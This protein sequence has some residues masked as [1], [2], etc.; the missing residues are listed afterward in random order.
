MFLQGKTS[1]SSTSSS[2]N[3]NDYDNNNSSSSK[4]T[5]RILS[6]PGPFLTPSPSPSISASPRLQPS[7]SLSPFPQDVLLV[8]G[9]PLTNANA[10]EQERKAV[11]PGRRQSIHQFTN[12][13]PNAGTVVFQPS[14]SQ[15]PA[16][17]TS[18]IGITANAAGGLNLVGNFQNV[19]TTTATTTGNDLNATLVGS[20]NIQLNKKG[21]K[22]QQQQHQQ[23]QQQQHHQIFSSSNSHY[24]NSNATTTTNPHPPHPSSSSIAAAASSVTS[25]SSTTATIAGGYG[26]SHA[27]TINN[28]PNT[29]AP[30]NVACTPK[31]Q[32]KK[33]VNA[34]NQQSNNTTASSSSA[35]LPISQQQHQQ[36]QQYHSG[37]P[38]IADSPSPSPSG[39]TITAAS[40]KPPTPQP[41]QPPTMQM[42]QQQFT[43]ASNGNGGTGPQQTFQLIQGPQG[44]IIA[45]ATSAPQHQQQARFTTTPTGNLTTTTTGG[46]TSATM[47]GNA[48]GNKLPQQIL[49]KPQQ[50]QQQQ[51]QILID[52]QKHKQGNSAGPNPTPPPSHQTVT[53]NATSSSNLSQQHQQQQ[54]ASLT[55]ISQSA[56]PG[57]QQ[58]I[59]PSGA[60]ASLT[61]TAGQQP[62]LLL[63]QV[64]M[65]VQQ[66]AP[67]G[68]QLILRPPTP[69][70]TATPS[71]VIQ[72]ARPQPQLQQQQP[73]QVLRILGHNG[74]TMQLA[75][76]TPTFIVS[77]QANLIQQANHLQAIKTQPQ[78]S[79]ITQLSGL[80]AALSAAA[81]ANQQPRSQQFTTTAATINGHLLGPSMAAQLQNLQLAAAAAANGNS[82]TAQIQMPNGLSASGAPT[83][84]SQ[85]PA[86]TG[87]TQFQQNS[88][89]GLINLNQLSNANIQ[90][91]AAAAAAAA[92][93]GATTFQA[94]G[95]PPSNNTGGQQGTQNVTGNTNANQTTTNDLYTTSLTQS[96]PA[97]VPVS[98]TPEPLSRQP[99]PVLQ[100]M[101]P[102]PS[103]QQHQHQQQHQQTVGGNG[104]I[105]LQFN[106]AATIQMQQ[107]QQ[108]QQQ[109]Q[110]QQL[111]QQIQQTQNQVQQAQQQAQALQ[112]Q[113]QQMQ[114]QQQQPPPPETKKKAKPRRRKPPATSAAANANT[115]GAASSTASPA[116]VKPLTT[117]AN[118]TLNTATSTTSVL[119]PAI[120]TSNT[121]TKIVPMLSQQNSGNL[122]TVQTTATVQQQQIQQNVVDNQ[123][124]QHQQQ[125][126]TK[127]PSPPPQITRAS[128]G[129]LD[130]GNVMKLCGI[131]EDDDEDFMDTT[132]IEETNPSSS[133]QMSNPSTDYTISIPQANV[134]GGD[135]PPPSYTLSIPGV[136]NDQMD[137]SG[138]ETAAANIVIKI[139]PSTE[140]LGSASG[141]TSGPPGHHPPY[142]I[143]IPRLPSQEE[144]QKQ[145]QQHLQ[146]AQNEAQQIKTSMSGGP[147]A[148][149]TFTLPL[150]TAGPTSIALGSS[151]ASSSTVTTSATSTTN[152]TTTTATVK[153][154]RKPAAKRNTKKTD[155]TASTATTVP[156]NNSTVTVSSSTTT[157]SFG[158]TLPTSSA[159]IVTLPSSQNSVQPNINITT[160]SISTPLPTP[161][162]VPSQIGNIQ[163]SQIDNRLAGQ[164]G[165]TTMVSTTPMGSLVENKIQ[166]M[167]ILDKSAATSHQP[168]QTQI[169]FQPPSLVQNHQ[170]IG[171]ANISAPLTT[172]L[173]E[174]NQQPR[175]MHL[176]SLPQLSNSSVAS[177]SSSPPVQQQQQQPQTQTAPP[178]NSVL[179]GLTGNVSISVGT[180]NTITSLIPQLTGSLTLAVS[181]QCERL[182][183]RH[184]PNKPQDQQSQLILQAL[185]KGALPN[186]TIINEPLKPVEPQQQ[187]QQQQQHSQVVTNVIQQQQ[188]QQQQQSATPTTVSTGPPSGNAKGSKKKQQQQQQQHVAP[189]ASKTT[190]SGGGVTK[191][192]EPTTNTTTAVQPQSNM[193]V[194]T[195]INNNPAPVPQQDTISQ[196]RYLSLPKID[197]TTQQLFCLNSLNNQIT[198]IGANQTTTSIGPTERILI[199]P[200]G[201]NAQQLAQCLQLGQIHFNDANPLP[202]SSQI[203]QNNPPPSLTNTSTTLPVHP[204]N[205]AGSI[206]NNSNTM[207]GPQQPP[208]QQIVYPMTSGSSTC[209]TVQSSS[210]TITT[211]TITTTTTTTKQVA[212][213]APIIDQSKAAKQ[214]N[215]LN[216]STTTTTTTTS[217]TGAVPKK[218]PVRKPKA[219]TTTAADVALMKN[220]SVVKPLPKLDPLS[221]KPH[222]NPVQI[223]QPNT[224]S[225]KPVVSTSTTST[226]T[227]TSNVVSIQPF[228]TQTSTGTKLVGITA[229]MQQQPQL[230]QQQ[231]QQQLQQNRTL[232]SGVVPTLPQPSIANNTTSSTGL[233]MSLPTIQPIVSTG[234]NLQ[235]QQPQHTVS[236]VQTIQLTQQQEQMLR[237]VQM[238]IQY[239]TVKMQHKNLISSMPLPADLD[240]SVVAAFN[241]PMSDI[242][243]N[244]SL[245]RLFMEQH[246]I[247]SS[248]KEISTSDQFITNSIPPNSSYNLGTFNLMSNTNQSQSASNDNKGLS[249]GGGIPANVVQPN[250][251]SANTSGVGGSTTTT[252]ALMSPAGNMQ[253]QQQQSTQKIHIYPIQHQ[254]HTTVTSTTTTSVAGTVLTSGNNKSK[255]QVCSSTSLSTAAA[256]TTT[257][258][259]TTSI[260]TNIIGSNSNLSSIP[261]GSVI[262]QQQQQ[263]ANLTSSLLSSPQ[264]PQLSSLSS[265]SNLS[266][267]PF[268]SLPQP[269]MINITNM[270][271]VLQQ[272]HF[273]QHLQMQQQ[274][275]LQQQKIQIAK[276]NTSSP[277]FASF[278]SVN[279][280]GSLSAH[281]SGGGPPPLIFPCSS[282]VSSTM[283]TTITPQLTSLSQQHQFSTASSLASNAF[284]I[285]S[286]SGI[287]TG[288]TNQKSFILSTS[289]GGAPSLVPTATLSS[290]IVSATTST[291]N[292][293]AAAPTFVINNQQPTITS[294]SAN[295]CST[296]N[297]LT[298]VGSSMPTSL[299]I[300]MSMPSMST[301]TPTLS[302]PQLV[303]ATTAV[304]VPPLITTATATTSLVSSTTSAMHPIAAAGIQQQQ[305]QQL[306]ASGS[307][308]TTAT[309][310]ICSTLANSNN[311]MI[312]HPPTTNPIINA[313]LNIV[314]NPI[315]QIASFIKTEDKVPSKAKLARL[316]LFL[317]QLEA[318]QQNCVKPDYKN[319]FQNKEEA[320]KRLIR[321]HC[322]YQNDEDIPSEEE[323]EF[324]KTAIRFQDKFRKLSGKFQQILLQESML[325]H[326]TSEI[327]QMEKLLIDDLRQE[328]ADSK[329]LEQ[330]L[331]K[332]EQECQ[333]QQQQQPRQQSQPQQF[334]VK[335]SLFDQL[336][337]EIKTETQDSKPN[338]MDMQSNNDSNSNF[339]TNTQNATSSFDSIKNEIK[340]ESMENSSMAGG[341]SSNSSID[342]F[343]LLKQSP[344]NNNMSGA[345]NM[346]TKTND[347]K[348]P[349]KEECSN[350]WSGETQTYL[351]SKNQN[352][353]YSQQQQQSQHQQQMQHTQQKVSNSVFNGGLKK[354]T[355]A[356]SSSMVQNSEEKAKD[357][358]ENFDI[359]SEI[360]P[361]FIMKKVEHKELPPQPHIN[362][363][364]AGVTGSSNTTIS[365]IT[366]S[367]NTTTTPAVNSLASNKNKSKI[368]KFNHVVETT[369][370]PTDS[371]QPTQSSGH[372]HQQLQQPQQH[373]IQNSSSNLNADSIL[374]NNFDFSHLQTNHAVNKQQEDDWLCIQKELNLINTAS[375]TNTT[376]TTNDNINHD[377]KHDNDNNQ[378]KSLDFLAQESSQGI[379]Q[380]QQQPHQTQVTTN[381]TTNCNVPSVLA[382][383]NNTTTTPTTSSCSQQNQQ[384]AELSLNNHGE[385]SHQAD[386]NEFFSGSEDSEVHKAVET[387][388]ES[389][390]GESPVHLSGSKDHTDSPYNLEIM[391]YGESAKSSTAKLFG[392]SP[393]HLGGTGAQKD[394]ID[395]PYNMS[396]L[397]GEAVKS[398]ASGAAVNKTTGK[399]T[400]ESDF[401]DNSFLSTGQAVAS[402]FANNTPN[403]M[404]HHIQ[405]GSANNP[406]WMQNMEAQFPVFSNTNNTNSSMGDCLGN[407]KRQWNG[408]M[409]DETNTPHQQQ[410]QQQHCESSPQKK[411]CGNINDSP[412]SAHSPL[413]SHQQQQ[414]QDSSQQQHHHN[415]VPNDTAHAQD[416]MDAALLSLHDGLGV[417]NATPANQTNGY[418]HHMIMTPTGFDNFNHMDG[419]QQQQNLHQNHFM[420]VNQTQQQQQQMM[421]NHHSNTGGGHQHNQHHQQQN[422]AATSGGGGE[423]DDDITRHVQNAIESILN[424]QS[425]EADSLSF[426]LDH[427]M[428]VLL[429][430][431]M[432]QDQPATNNAGHDANKR[433]QLVD[434]LGDC[435]MG[436][437]SGAGGSNSSTDAVNLTDNHLIMNHNPHSHHTQLM[438]QQQHPLSGAGNHQ[439]H[440]QHHQHLVSATTAGNPN[441][442][443]TQLNDF[444]CVI[445]G[446]SNI[447]S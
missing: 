438:Q 160:S 437:G 271:A 372:Q 341:K 381:T 159:S 389:M 316:S 412:T 248:G 96:S 52:T 348:E 435:I 383:A 30:T 44:Q 66:N 140:L 249:G 267:L 273:T 134:S 154:R 147:T 105:H 114:Q 19:A 93:A 419:Q 203:L 10:H 122:T 313:G 2:S 204:M 89:Q 270:P 407:R 401:T 61:T 309:A 42:L 179:P 279:T 252:P 15:S 285:N 64:P 155:N 69:Q 73:Q 9:N 405:L 306:S 247:L 7:P 213:V 426:S 229:P 130:L 364:S 446:N 371:M 443:Q 274:Q 24:T 106:A 262:L 291:T 416:L 445:G 176:V 78:N 77:S 206:L 336:K 278:H 312:A 399:S 177:N 335:E 135:A 28:T 124:Q 442:Q 166:I 195:N 233:Q 376:T 277:A 4:P 63:N 41:Q 6:P 388:L 292:V 101:Q 151:V 84:L 360:T 72:N 261:G 94:P 132:P 12:G 260:A 212:N 221:Q 49:P 201:I 425:S 95:A 98:V 404:T 275:L 444:N 71:L 103:P 115:A 356:T 57:Q 241:K 354:S 332:Y 361:T 302:L 414:K 194:Q 190:G 368:Q 397:F 149:I 22:R 8:T 104:Q 74:A 234:Q 173:N 141:T 14:P 17:A 447:S 200:A 432:M 418:N 230:Q 422:T 157:T 27:T 181:E 16:A 352:T 420:N 90:Q 385:E 121:T 324:E 211:T 280:S 88:A 345:G 197:P 326:R 110:I 268:A 413:N 290:P 46:I 58:I 276:V 307:F 40:I 223:V 427:S 183:L 35:V 31:N 243:I 139:D 409:V 153:P 107:Q 259:I 258:N 67:Q 47:L 284:T 232:T 328:I 188:Q 21:N 282:T 26:Q 239:L 218:K 319:P 32:T 390:F 118:K 269:H 142:S 367:S 202:P 51:Q 242:E 184:D 150:A 337:N 369:P 382:N 131:T 116:N 250:N 353:F 5:N 1:L 126:R 346:Q 59:L 87:T 129:K 219:S 303:M 254:Q 363:T 441:Q 384:P 144:I 300:S 311:I 146:Q 227:S 76:A 92:A 244:Q 127:S 235:Q 164:H 226:T 68:V 152:T 178:T 366:S 296:A 133:N 342:S 434:E 393:V 370:Q 117:T 62:Q 82:L 433:Q 333:N 351:D 398:P 305:H 350:Q 186:V 143:T 199:A 440:S 205:N 272:K 318:D 60:T 325:Q 171:G 111:Q 429:G 375:S 391:G 322:M 410:Q 246:R 207:S 128:N 396:M 45:A 180:P 304:T 148:N 161:S 281:V 37:S 327:C 53:S 357:S 365:A 208:K 175:Q 222:N 321:Y 217:S 298:T 314:G 137:H 240:P 374:S 33:G 79:A 34:T 264:L 439:Q 54:Q 295:S 55:Q 379:F 196:Q 189:E 20:N 257:S 156:A 169:V 340:T 214:E 329:K 237:Q 120:S 113:Q 402:S 310:P 198:P 408:H 358:F 387:R 294:S 216:S 263:S 86:S 238:Q 265:T 403:N 174:N 167:P 75:A 377:Q 182:I 301:T 334:D 48:K 428:G 187:Q 236:R 349:K 158:N 102:A 299:T 39:T 339:C 43:I 293:V 394:R 109:Q 436:G 36:F 170:G 163:I 210:S 29:F 25:A 112:Q 11:T 81:A 317:Q 330:D 359:E 80:H 162:L 172:N 70:L 100:T 411:I 338:L 38:L 331:F 400:W 355:A 23:Q 424:L 209:A 378:N 392:D 286:L 231:Q 320:V 266:S 18:V 315:S 145:A 362:I 225:G 380:Q 415:L 119:V 344:V 251:H 220:A 431:S 406:R 256:T 245:Q 99:T 123:Q 395:S 125:Q 97:H 3:T 289:M 288:L 136:T 215:K 228:Q 373:P 417:D 50:Q 386:L 108:Q 308:T 297:V 65:L 192:Q 193:N 253:Q 283:T 91:I 224:A 168:Q 13:S 83:L 347:A 138:T 185:L 287:G 56:Q 165:A 430:N 191:A 343:D 323:E 255:Q 421:M 423:Y 85:L